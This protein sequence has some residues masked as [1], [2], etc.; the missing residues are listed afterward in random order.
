MKAKDIQPNMVYRKAGRGWARHI[1]TDITVE[2]VVGPYSR[3][4]SNSPRTFIS[5][6]PLQSDRTTGLIKIGE[7]TLVRLQDIDDFYGDYPVPFGEHLNN[8][9]ERAEKRREERLEDEATERVN[10]AAVAEIPDAVW[11]FLQVSQYSRETFGSYG[12][13]ARLGS[14]GKTDMLITVAMVQRIAQWIADEDV[15]V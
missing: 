2:P 1:L 5:V 14:D 12:P 7:P 11:D 15:A 10:R 9:V 6:Q 13:L 8:E 4:Y 3:S